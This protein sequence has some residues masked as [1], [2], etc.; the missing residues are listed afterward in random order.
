MD[1]SFLHSCHR[2]GVADWESQRETCKCVVIFV[3]LIE[4][5]L[6]LFWANTVVQVVLNLP[7]TDS[8]R[9]LTVLSPGGKCPFGLTCEIPRTFK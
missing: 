4:L 3:T 1:R 9:A 5:C 8:R 6:A 2:R 7:Q